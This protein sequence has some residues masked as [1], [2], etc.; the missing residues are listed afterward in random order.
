MSFVGC[1]LIFFSL[2]RPHTLTHS[3]KDFLSLISS[4]DF[5]SLMEEKD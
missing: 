2:F 5:L 1:F 3:P 4:E